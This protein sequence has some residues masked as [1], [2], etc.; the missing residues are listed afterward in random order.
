MGFVILETNSMQL[1]WLR[2]R[3]RMPKIVKTY[4]IGYYKVEFESVDGVVRWTAYF[5][6]K[7]STEY[8]T[9]LWD[10]ED[11]I[12]GTAK[13]Q[14]HAEKDAMQALRNQQFELTGNG[15]VVADERQIGPT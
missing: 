9:E 10:D 8:W 4:Q 7:H 12:Y 6:D 2:R 5:H 11:L 15:N 14:E 1:F 3:A 13:T